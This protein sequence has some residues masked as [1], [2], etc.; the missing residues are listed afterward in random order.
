[1]KAVINCRACFFS[2]TSALSGDNVEKAAAMDSEVLSIEVSKLSKGIAH[3][4]EVVQLIETSMS[5]DHKQKFTES[6]L[7]FMRMRRRF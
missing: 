5:G 6:M 7:K 2:E 3:I 4:A 1:M